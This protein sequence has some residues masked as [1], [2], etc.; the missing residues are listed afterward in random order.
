MSTK[1]VL[2]TGAAGFIGFHTCIALKQRGG[3]VIGLDNYNDYY[4]PQLKYDRAAYLARKGIEVVKGDIN[5]KAMLAEII[6]KHGITHIIHLAAQAGVRYSLSN[7]EAYVKANLEGFLSVLELCRAN[8]H[9]PLVYASSSS[10]YGLNDKIPFSEQDRTDRQASLYGVTK[11]SNELMAQTYHHLFGISVCGLRFFTVYGPWGR[12]DMAYFSFVKAILAGESI[13][14]FNHGQLQRDFTYIDDIVAG[15]L[16]ALDKSFA[17]EVFNLGNHKSVELK[18]FVQVIEESLGQ[19]AKIN[20]VPMQSGDVLKTYADIA[21][22]RQL[23]GFNPQTS[24]E[25][26]I[27]KFVEWYK[28]YYKSA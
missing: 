22:S 26:G 17:C 27:P 13:D 11:K 8:P 16:A 28:E 1:K 2:V 15:I 7:P 21:H 9:I 5:D 23:L 14:L 4:I 12:P 18:R 25:E 24:L 3:F 10:V 20:S 19:K 6:K